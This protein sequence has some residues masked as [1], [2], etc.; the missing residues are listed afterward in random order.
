M[1][2]FVGRATELGLLG[3]AMA[4]ARRGVPRVVVVEGAAGIGKST[5]V[6]RFVTGVADAR[7]L[8]ASGD[9]AESRLGYGIVT[10]LA[11]CAALGQVSGLGLG[12]TMSDE[13]DPLAIGAQ[14]LALLGAVQ[15]SDKVV[16]V[17]VDDLHLADSLSAKALLFAL[18]RLSADRVMGLLSV[19][20][21][22]AAVLGQG[23]GRFVAGDHRASRVRLGGFGP[24]DLMEL[25]RL[26]GGGEL[27]FRT[28]ARLAEHTQGNPLYCRILLQELGAQGLEASGPNLRIPRTLAAVLLLRLGSLSPSAQALVTAAAVLGRTCPLDTAAALARVADPLQALDEA[29]GASLLLEEPG[30]GTT[31][32]VFAHPLVQQAVLGDL[33]PSRRHRLHERAAGL[34]P[35]V[36]ALAH[37]VAA[38]VAPDPELA[39]DLE[40]LARHTR[41]AG[42]TVQAAFWLAH[43]S[44]LSTDPDRDRRLLD[45]FEALL[46]AGDVAG[47]SALVPRL[48]EAGPSARKSALL[49]HLDLLTGKSD[50]AAAHLE[51]AWAAH[52]PA[53]EPLVGAKAALQ[54]F[55]STGIAGRK[56]EA[57]AW[58]ERAVRGAASDPATRC[59]A[60]SLVAY[61]LALDGHGQEGLA[62]LEPLPSSPTAVPAGQT[63]ALIMRGATRLFVEDL[64]GAVADLST[65]AA[66]VRAGVPTSRGSECLSCLA[67]A[68]YRLGSWD[69]AVMHAELAVSLAR[70]ADRYIDLGF[71]HAYATLVPA[72]RG[73]WDVAKAHAEAAW[74]AAPPLGVMA[75]AASVTA[76]AALATAAGDHDEVLRAIAA[77]RA[78]GRADAFGRPGTYDWRP[79]EIQ[80]HISLGQLD[81][82]D[83]ALAE[84]E[85][86]TT[87]SSPA[88]AGVVAAQ[89]RGNLVVAR[90]D[91]SAAA[92]AF[93]VAYQRSEGLRLPFRLACLHA[94]DGRRLRC[95]G[96]RADAIAR[97]RLARG[98]FVALAA[99]PYLERCDQELAACGIR[100]PPHDTPVELGL[101]PAELAVAR[102]VATGRSNRDAAAELYVSV[103]TV[104]F[105]LRHIFTKLGINS[106]KDLPQRFR[107]AP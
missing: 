57:M 68:E 35:P 49:G 104:E 100:V 95:S 51:E 79:L 70:T 71:S 106:R 80:A 33:S 84:L 44:A 9:E 18:R 5:L 97:L 64:P 21:A 103:K 60:L 19:R 28:A 88:S 34:V 24:D 94:D 25:C 91:E 78:T 101:S 92:Y 96:R 1:S 31:R 26:V 75:I 43:A 48:D 36:E 93:A 39:N 67:D 62:L 13:V 55:V 61:G 87:T 77:L 29:V 45:A 98:R 27:S 16:V 10:Q 56:A 41:N 99:R 2:E 90:G 12:Q 58:G 74:R 54:L 6:S 22:E 107:E 3:V 42:Q 52:D 66:R 46:S 81:S 8:R 65:A 40:E 86:A 20:P 85:A 105:H 59:H 73:E 50:A 89:L 76:R 47:A 15:Q 23:W 63:D 11:A 37:R 17:V 72:A 82:A 83:A 53:R 102:L 4:E 32:I 69:D 14:L 38:A 30:G 7:I